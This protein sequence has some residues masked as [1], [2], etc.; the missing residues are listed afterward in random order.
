MERLTD[1]FFSMGLME[2]FEFKAPKDRLLAIQD[3]MEKEV[4]QAIN[5]IK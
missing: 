5:A 1:K 4:G 2:F 3:Q